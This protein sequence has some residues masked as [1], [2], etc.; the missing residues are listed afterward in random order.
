MSVSL[1]FTVHVMTI[2]IHVDT[3]RST[4]SATEDPKDRVNKKRKLNEVVYEKLRD[5]SSKDHAVLRVMS[6]ESLEGDVC[7][8]WSGCAYVSVEMENRDSVK[9]LQKKLDSGELRRAFEE[10]LITD[11]LKREF[12]V[13]YATLAVTGQDWEQ[14]MCLQ[15]LEDGKCM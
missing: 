13:S 9:R 12:A 8:V 14:Q 10:A 15:E 5:R 11:D 4:N 3:M 7:E 2:G 6:K 1:L